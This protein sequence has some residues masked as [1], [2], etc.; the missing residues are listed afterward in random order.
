MPMKCYDGDMKLL[1]FRSA[2][3]LSY[4][5]QS[6][7]WQLD[8]KKLAW[9]YAQRLRRSTFTITPFDIAPSHTIFKFDFLGNDDA[10][11]IH[12]GIVGKFSCRFV[13]LVRLFRQCRLLLPRQ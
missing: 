5:V 10:H 13:D 9:Y 7:I 11:D 6:R 8:N 12:S 2:T 1:P 3:P 4:P